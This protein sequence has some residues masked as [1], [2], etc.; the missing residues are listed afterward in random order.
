LLLVVHNHRVESGV[1]VVVDRHLLL[2]SI[3]SRRIACSPDDTA[4]PEQCQ[5]I[6]D[7]YFDRRLDPRRNV[8]S[9][10]EDETAQLRTDDSDQKHSACFEKA[11]CLRV[12]LL[13]AE[14]FLIKPKLI[15]ATPAVSGGGTPLSCAGRSIG[16][17]IRRHLFK[18]RSIEAAARS[19]VK[20]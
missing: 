17:D 1:F 16:L 7:N 6:S 13:T 19:H 12:S 11:Q 2:L 5:S 20:V 18:P 8:I 10:T 3:C 9:Q 4:G 14:Q 15:R